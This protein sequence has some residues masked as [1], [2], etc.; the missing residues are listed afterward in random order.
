MFS[1]SR[2]TLLGNSVEPCALA[3]NECVAVSGPSGSGKTMLLRALADLD[4]NTAHVSLDKKPREDFTPCQWR[5]HVMLIP[6]EPAWWH[7][8]VGAHFPSSRREDWLA[9]LGLDPGVMQWE[10]S[11]LSSGEL[12]RLGL[13]RALMREPQV[14]LLDEPTANLDE[15]RIGDVET[16]IDTYLGEK[17][18]RCA[19]WVSHDRAQ[20]ERVAQRQLSLLDHQWT[21]Q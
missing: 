15:Q 17:P 4:L 2:F 21:C 16:L 5:Q 1:F 14:L 11:R 3:Q 19:L 7:D 18:R 6:A 20:R 8:H 9:A 10:V 13:L 12:Q